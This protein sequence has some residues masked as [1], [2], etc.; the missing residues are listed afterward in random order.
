MYAG[1]ANALGESISTRRTIAVNI[2]HGA[3][4]IPQ[5]IALQRVRL[6]RP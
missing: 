4:L 5:A 2:E 3:V 1:P 6:T